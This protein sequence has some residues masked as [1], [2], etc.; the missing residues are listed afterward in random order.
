MDL[1]NSS[2]WTGIAGAGSNFLG[3]IFNLGTGLSTLAYQKELQREIFRREDTAIQRRVADLKAAGLSPTLAAG[4]AA[5]AGAAINVSAPELNTNQF[6][7]ALN[8]AVKNAISDYKASEEAKLMSTQRA[9]NTAEVE[10]TKAQTLNA[11]KQ[12]NIFDEQLNKLFLE[13]ASSALNLSMLENKTQLYNRFGIDADKKLSGNA[14]AVGG[15]FL[16]WITGGS[17]KDYPRFNRYGFDLRNLRAGKG[18][19]LENHGLYDWLFHP[20]SY[21][22]HSSKGGGRW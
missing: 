20:S 16:N 7:S 1:A 4:S 11:L 13:N 14:L 15:K 21:Y 19:L 22:E 9:K 5:N 18:P 10:Y 12:G 17:V 2:F 8:D 3:S 6:A